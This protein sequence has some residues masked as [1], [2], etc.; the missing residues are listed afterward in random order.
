MCRRNRRSAKL[1]RQDVEKKQNSDASN[2]SSDQSTSL[3]KSLDMLRDLISQASQEDLKTMEA[4]CSQFA[5]LASG[6]VAHGPKASSTMSRKER[7]AAAFQYKGKEEK[8]DTDASNACSDF[9]ILSLKSVDMLEELIRHASEQDLRKVE[10]I[11]TQVVSLVDPSVIQSLDTSVTTD[12][13]QR[14]AAVPQLKRHAEQKDSDASE[15]T[16]VPPSSPSESLNMLSGL[17]EA[18]SQVG[19]ASELV[20]KR[21]EELCEQI[22]LLADNSVSGNNQPQM[23]AHRTQATDELRPILISAVRC[24]SRGSAE[25]VE[26]LAPWWL[27]TVQLQLDGIMMTSELKALAE[28]LR[29]EQ[30][31]AKHFDFLNVEKEVKKLIERH[32][33][34][35]RNIAPEGDG[36]L[37][38]PYESWS[39]FEPELHRGRGKFSLQF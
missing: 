3:L 1:Q 11:F 16:S 22:L 38:K 25:A 34:A 39:T 2:A 13:K 9:S 21:V 20:V 15:I 6:S 8:H 31:N 18:D 24:V 10:E 14:R 23:I 28:A 37:C 12:R 4:I 36:V 27:L 7:R 5:T 19:E 17:P 35:D 29:N 33:I 30:L 26:I 32:L